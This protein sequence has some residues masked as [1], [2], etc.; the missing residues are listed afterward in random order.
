MMKLATPV[1]ILASMLMPACSSSPSSLSALERSEVGEALSASKIAITPCI[2]GWLLDES[3][4][5]RLTDAD[6][7]AVQEIIL[8]GRLHIMSSELNDELMAEQME[9]VEKKLFY[10]YA[11][12]ELNI[13]GY[14]KDEKIYLDD[15][16]LSAPDQA[17]LY[18]LLLPYVNKL[19][20]RS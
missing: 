19:P 3:D 4:I 9:D 11:S 16:Q 13:A 15:V 5:H 10:L 18:A 1:L 8:R 12:N 17:A 2:P 20:E 6:H 7:E 14:T